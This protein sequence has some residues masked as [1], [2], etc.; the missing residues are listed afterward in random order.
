MSDNL[1][2]KKIIYASENILELILEKILMYLNTLAKVITYLNLFKWL[3]V[4]V[5]IIENL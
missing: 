4:S 1:N 2:N 5:I 3:L